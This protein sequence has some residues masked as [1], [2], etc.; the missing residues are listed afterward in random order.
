MLNVS[1][2]KNFLNYKYCTCSWIKK[3]NKYNT[4]QKYQ[5]TICDKIKFQCKIKTVQANSIRIFKNINQLKKMK[6]INQLKL[7][8]LKKLSKLESSKQK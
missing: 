7:S 3:W 1:S 4:N 8:D 2:L 5:S 6:Y